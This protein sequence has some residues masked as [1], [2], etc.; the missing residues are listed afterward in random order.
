MSI[1]FQQRRYYTTPFLGLLVC[2]CVRWNTEKVADR[3][4]PDFQGKQAL[5]MCWVKRTTF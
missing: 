3:F 4:A 2:A 5:G 1:F